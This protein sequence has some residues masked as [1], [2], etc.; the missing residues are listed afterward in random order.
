MPIGRIERPETLDP[1]LSAEAEQVVQEAS[2]AMMKWIDGAVDKLSQDMDKQLEAA[3]KGLEDQALV[4]EKDYE[5][6]GERLTRLVAEINASKAS[7][8]PDTSKAVVAEWQKKIEEARDWLKK[9][10]ERWK[11]AGRDAIKV[12]VATAKK[13]IIG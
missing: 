4:M 6:A 12:A 2:G 7:L 8:T 11:G 9:R 5:E 3:A 13:A 10:E 1:N